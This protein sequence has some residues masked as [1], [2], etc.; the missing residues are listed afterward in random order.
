[1]VRQYTLSTIDRTE[2]KEQIDICKNC[3]LPVDEGNGECERYKRES[4]KLREV[5][6]L[7]KNIILY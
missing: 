1:M 3:T 2:S 4:K 5:K 6:R 7:K